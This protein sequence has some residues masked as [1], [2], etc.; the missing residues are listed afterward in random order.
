[1]GAF[2]FFQLFRLGFD[3]QPKLFHEENS[4]GFPK[5]PKMAINGLVI[6]NTTIYSVFFFFLSFFKRKLI[7]N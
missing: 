3:T 6:F 5:L 7:V 2:P 4:E 1:V